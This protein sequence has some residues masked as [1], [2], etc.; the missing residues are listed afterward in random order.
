MTSGFTS[1]RPKGEPYTMTVS[2]KITHAA[3]SEA[4]ALAEAS[5]IGTRSV[6]PFVVGW[7]EELSL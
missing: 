2:D 3:I 1:R 7:R 5:R 6:A 4:S